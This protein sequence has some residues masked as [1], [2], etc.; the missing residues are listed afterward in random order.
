MSSTDWLVLTWLTVLG[1]CIG[2][3]LNVVVYRLP[4]GGSL[5]GRSQCPKCKHQIRAYHNVP[6]FGWMMLRGKCRDCGQQ[7]SAR[8]PLVEAAT[9]ATFAALFFA[10]FKVGDPASRGFAHERSWTLFLS[11]AI[12]CSALICEALI[13][14]DGQ[15]V[16]RS[17]RWIVTIAA[18]VCGL[19][20]I[21]M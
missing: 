19:A 4:R 17:I 11:G 21:L 10:A 2:S 3:F 6:V 14:L 18:V 9:A 16:P 8:Y 13:Q 15:I 7:I 20:V 12:L 5:Q 1:G